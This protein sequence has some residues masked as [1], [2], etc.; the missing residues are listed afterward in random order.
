MVSVGNRLHL[1]T[2]NRF[3][4]SFFFFALDGNRVEKNKKDRRR[5]VI[6]QFLL[7]CTVKITKLLGVCVCVWLYATCPYIRKR[8]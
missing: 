4:F 1:E 3:F 7:T 8:T 6:G 5:S 2:K